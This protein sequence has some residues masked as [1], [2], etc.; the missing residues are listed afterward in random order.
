MEIGKPDRIQL[1]LAMFDGNP[2]ITIFV[3]SYLFTVS[4]PPTIPSKSNSHFPQ[5]MDDKFFFPLP[6]HQTTL[7]VF[8]KDQYRKIRE[9]Q[10]K[11]VEI[12]CFLWKFIQ[13]T[14]YSINQ[15]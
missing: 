15:P 7:L 8:I 4:C 10:K 14:P 11:R 3:V 12:D 5:G 13:V 1:T 9:K 2:E 6:L